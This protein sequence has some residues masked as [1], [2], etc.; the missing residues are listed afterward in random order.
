L[1]QAPWDAASPKLQP[2]LAAKFGSMTL[3]QKPLKKQK[4]QFHHFKLTLLLNPRMALLN[5]L[6][7]EKEEESLEECVEVILLIICLDLD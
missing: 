1:A 6:W 4:M 5:P 7:E 3:R 2:K